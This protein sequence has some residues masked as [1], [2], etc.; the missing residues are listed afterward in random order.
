MVKA[1]GSPGS[2][3][4]TSLLMYRR[5][6]LSVTVRAARVLISPQVTGMEYTMPLVELALTDRAAV[7]VAICPTGTSTFQVMVRVAES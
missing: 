7:M 1:T 6:S 5:R 4:F 2:A 3:R